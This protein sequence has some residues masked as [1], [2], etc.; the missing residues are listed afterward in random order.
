MANCSKKLALKDL[1]ELYLSAI[2]GNQVS[3]S[4]L[5]IICQKIL[6]KKINHSICKEDLLH[7]VLYKMLKV[8]NFDPKRSSFYSYFLMFAHA[9]K[10]N[11]FRSNTRR[12]KSLQNFAEATTIFHAN[13]CVTIEETEENTIKD[14]LQHVSD[15]A[16]EILL[17]QFV[18][19]FTQSQISIIL[20][21]PLGTVKTKSSR[22]IKRIKT[23]LQ[24]KMCEKYQSQ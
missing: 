9:E 7:N 14:M 5:Y 21:M 17:L 1:T 16:A 23:R 10:I 11:I 8:K 6:H 18:H 12:K 2:G 4:E 22:A 15:D 20:D 24:R 19:G 3:F 13:P